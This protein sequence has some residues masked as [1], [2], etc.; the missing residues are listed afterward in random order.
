MK[1]YQINSVCGFGSTGK[2]AVDVKNVLTAKGHHSRIAYGRGFYDDADCYK[3]QKDLTFKEHILLSRI[4]DRQGF[5]SK[6]AT[7]KLVKD[8]KNY[9][10]DVIHLHNIHGYYINIPVLFDFLAEYSKP[11]VW[12]LHDCWTFTG[13]CAHFDFI[14]CDR[15]KTGCFN[16]PQKTVYPASFGLDSSKKNYE[17]K[18]KYFTA[19]K[20]LTLVTPSNWLNQLAKQSFFCDKDI[21][22]VNNG[23]DLE[24]FKPITGDF[25][26]KNG[27]SDKKIVLG[28]A[29]LWNDKKGLEDF[30]ELSKI[31]PEEYKIVLVGL[32]DKQIKA[33]PENILGLKRTSNAAELAELYTG[34]RVFVNPTYEDTFPTTN[35]EALATGTPVITYNTGGSVESVDE[36]CGFVVEKGDIKDL[37]EKIISADFKSE[38]CI[39]KSRNFE[40][41][42]SFNKYLEIYADKG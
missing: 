15:W 32:N 14:G 28:V 3:I 16:C 7:K 8:I 6:S 1:V 31:L 12:T 20:N 9:S 18:K 24:I 34:A 25:F 5:Y 19:I 39:L 17:Q 33:L 22:T 29:S 4:T 30:K 21:I 35:L 10:P 13:H 2:I 38:D 26:Q 40:K 27:I 11:V 42:K 37:A 23:I 41:E 36:K